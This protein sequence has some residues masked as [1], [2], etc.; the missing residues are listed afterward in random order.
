MKMKKI[1]LLLYSLVLSLIVLSSCKNNDDI[2]EQ[3]ANVTQSEALQ[4]ALDNLDTNLNDDGTL[5][6]IANPVGNIIFDF[7]FDFVYPI[8]LVYNNGTTVTA[9]SFEDLILILINSTEELFIVGIEFP[10]QVEIY[11]EET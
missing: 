10:F 3:M 5:N 1:K 9:N 4:T 2:V 6:D 7:C 8:E 11:N